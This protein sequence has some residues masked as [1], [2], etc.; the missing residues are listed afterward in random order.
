MF[1]SNRI[2][3]LFII[4]VLS[5]MACGV[6]GISTLEP[7][8]ISTL[9]QGTV[10]AA[11]TQSAV[12]AI[13]SVTPS[14]TGA[15]TF[16]L[17]PEPPTQT[18]TS[19]LTPTPTVT[20]TPLVPLISVSLP[21]NCR[22][23]PGKVYDYEGALLVGEIAE[24]IARDP[25]GNYWYIRNPDSGGN[26]CWL[27]GRY[28]TITGNTLILPV[29]T[30]PPTPTPTFTPKPTITPTPSPNFRPSYTSL[31][32]CTG[33]WVE[34]SLRNNGSITFRSVGITVQDTVTGVTITN[35][36]DGFTDLDGCLTTTT[37]DTLEPDKTYVISAPAFTYNPTGHLIRATITLCSN[38]GQNG[39]CV[40]KTIEF[41]P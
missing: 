18:P 16:T 33:W 20:F 7:S 35:F 8:A 34:I 19:T 1:S 23:G 38:A 4:L 37:R 32:T 13:P 36:K 31:D 29:Y 26:F 22:N 21:T 27:W 2:F 10:I 17:T 6:P 40:T 25:T 14:E 15:P 11:L 9:I 30:P 5:T 12:P 41:T 39:T 28:A 3:P 24:V